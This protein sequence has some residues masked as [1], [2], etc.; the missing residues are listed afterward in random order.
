MIKVQGKSE[1][2]DLKDAEHFWLE[3]ARRREPFSLQ[4]TAAL[5]ELRPYN[6]SLGTITQPYSLAKKGI[7]HAFKANGSQRSMPR[8]NDS[9]GVER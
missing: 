7:V 8:A 6:K 2:N 5:N 9:F 1:K 4:I 3:L